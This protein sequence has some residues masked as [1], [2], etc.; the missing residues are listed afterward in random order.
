[1]SFQ[2]SGALQ[3]SHIIF[4]P[5][6]FILLISYVNMSVSLNWPVSST[7]IV[8]WIYHKYVLKFRTFFSLCSQ[9]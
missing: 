9:N 7:G 1:M 8:I 5:T 3:N 6:D 2:S 4:V